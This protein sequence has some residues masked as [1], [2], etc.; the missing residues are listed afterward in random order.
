MHFL[1]DDL[2]A[3]IRSRAGEVDATNSF[4]AD[5]L[6]DLRGAG[7]LGAFVPV[8]FGGSGPGGAAAAAGTGEQ[9]GPQSAGTDAPKWPSHRPRARPAVATGAHA[10]SGPARGGRRAP[11]PLPWASGSAPSA[12]WPFGPSA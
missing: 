4:P 1:S 9:P 8:E 7:Y 10:S 2:L 3:R 12:R 11:M 6:A 5:D